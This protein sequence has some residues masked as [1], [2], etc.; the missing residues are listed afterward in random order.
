LRITVD[1]VTLRIDYYQAGSATP[2]D[3][4]SVDIETHMVT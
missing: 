2:T 3:T 4:V 1:P